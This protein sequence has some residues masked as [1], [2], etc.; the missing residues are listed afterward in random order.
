MAKTSNTGL[1][2]VGLV[3][4]V[5]G[6]GLAFWG[7]QL[8]GSLTSQVTKT[9]SGSMPDEVMFRYIGGAVCGVVGGFLLLK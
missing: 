7:Y 4:L 8:S 3:L 1:K 5:V 9:I 2:I 6:I